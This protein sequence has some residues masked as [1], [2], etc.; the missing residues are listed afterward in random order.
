MRNK[1]KI[2]DQIVGKTKKDLEKRKQYVP[3]GMLKKSI[4]KQRIRSFIKAIKNPK[5][6]RLAIIAEIKFASPTE[7][8]LGSSDLLIDRVGQYKAAGS[9]AISIVTEKNFF[10]G[11]PAYISKIKEVSSLPVLQKDFIVDPYQVYEVKKAGA[12]AILLIARIVSEEDL[13]LLTKEAQLIG[14]EVVVEVNSKD[15]LKRALSTE[16][17][18]IAVNARDLDTLE[19][20]VDR[21]CQF[22]KMIP[23][24]FIKLGFSGVKN[25]DEVEKYKNAG[26]DGVLIGT[27]LMKTDNIEAFIKNLRAI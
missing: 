9:D 13:R 1:V 19:V 25:K 23:D 14:L 27:S 10:K 11:D 3:L 24:R 8:H 6:G 18:I 12:D 15:D 4:N 7:S 5:G 26:A 16:A 20:D 22:L 21:A 17:K 2:I